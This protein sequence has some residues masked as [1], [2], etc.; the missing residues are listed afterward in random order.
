MK[1][2]PEYPIRLADLSPVVH[3]AHFVS[4][5]RGLSIEPRFIEDFELVYIVAGEG[6]YRILDA[7]FPYAAG[8]LILTPPYLRHSYRAYGTAVEHYALHFDPREGFSARFGEL[9]GYAGPASGVSIVFNDSTRLRLFY[10]DFDRRCVDRFERIRRLFGEL[11]ISAYAAAPLLLASAVLDLLALLVS[12]STGEAR[13]AFGK[14]AVAL[15]RLEERFTEPISVPELAALEGY[16]PNY[17]ASE[18]AKAYG[19]SPIEYLHAKRIALA[20]ELLGSTKD[21]I[22]V[23]ASRCG[24]EDPYYFSKVFKKLTRLSPRAYRALATPIGAGTQF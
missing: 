20:R 15:D 11:S 14:F 12:A 3:I 18:F 4:D 22:G 6:L 7:E 5:S 10:P 9:C 2:P 13:R 16:S 19:V 23:I 17:F 1:T 21:P 8:A 24:Y